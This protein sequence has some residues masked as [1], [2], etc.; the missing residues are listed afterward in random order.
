M[1]ERSSVSGAVDGTLL[2]DEE[3]TKRQIRDEVLLEQLERLWSS[4][5][6]D[7]VVSSSVSPSIEDKRALEMMEQS[8]KVVNG[9]F[10]VGLPWRTTPP[11]ICQITGLWLSGELD[12]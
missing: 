6:A 8:L 5:F 10:Q 3:N 7:S 9:H 1:I 2:C 11:L 12:F 4:D